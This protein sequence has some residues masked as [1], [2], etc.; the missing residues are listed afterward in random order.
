MST[1]IKNK[2][3]QKEFIVILLNAGFEKMPWDKCP[4]GYKDSDYQCFYHKEKNIWC[5]IYPDQWM[6]YGWIVGQNLKSSKYSNGKFFE[7]TKELQSLLNN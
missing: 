5:E 3:L 6:T 4:K 1:A 2:S 7:T